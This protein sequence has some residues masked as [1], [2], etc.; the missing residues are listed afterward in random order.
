MVALVIMISMSLA[1]NNMSLLMPECRM[2]DM[3]KKLRLWLDIESGHR[4]RDRERLSDRN[5]CLLNNLRAAKKRWTTAI[6]VVRTG[7]CTFVKNVQD[8]AVLQ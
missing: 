7:C 1:D 6:F 3:Q 8:D 2:P 4:F 5:M